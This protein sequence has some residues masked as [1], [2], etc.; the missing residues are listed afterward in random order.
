MEILHAIESIA[1]P[2]KS[3][4]R[5]RQDRQDEKKI[6]PHLRT[7]ERLL[8]EVLD[9]T[10]TLI[11]DFSLQEGTIRAPAALVNPSGVFLFYFDPRRGVFRARAGKWEQ[12]DER[13]KQFRPLQPNPIQAAEAQ[14][15][16]LR[17]YLAA[18]GYP[19]VS[20]QA[21]IVFTDTGAHLETDQ[22]EV[23]LL[24][25]DG[26]PRFAAA[27]ARAQPTL[28]LNEVRSLVPLLAK[29]TMTFPCEKRNRAQPKFLRLSFPCR[30]MIPCCGRFRKC[31]L[32]DGNCW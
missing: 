13:R 32:R 23:R 18:Q 30:G 26:F 24:H 19:Q 25:L 29:F 4:P 16:A 10:A 8:A 27:L 2:P 6:L 5:K 7:L 1:S 12:L 17:A 31:L 22:S 28:T 21:L 14:Q 11:V 15:T 20:V 3:S 9:H